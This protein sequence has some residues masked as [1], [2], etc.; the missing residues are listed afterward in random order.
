[1]LQLYYLL[2]ISNAI[3][4]LI[5]INELL[6]KEPASQSIRSLPERLI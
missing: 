6:F 3:E 1:M 5:E 4:Y 2:H